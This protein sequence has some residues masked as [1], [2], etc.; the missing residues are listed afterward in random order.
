MTDPLRPPYESGA[1]EAR[2]SVGTWSVVT[3]MTAA[4]V[5]A[6]S[7]AVIMLGPPSAG[8]HLTEAPVALGQWLIEWSGSMRP[9]SAE[10]EE[11]GLALRLVAGGAAALVSVLCLLIVSGLW[12]QRLLLRKA[13]YFVHWAVGARRIQLAARLLGEGRVWVGGAVVLTLLASAIIVALIERT[14]PGAAAVSPNMAATAIVLLGLGVVLARWEVGVG[15]V[16]HEA[17]RSR[18]WELLASPPIVGAVGFAA[19]SGV[20]VLARHAP[21]PSESSVRSAGVVI[22][23]SLG[24]LPVES[25]GEEIISWTERARA[26]GARIGFASAGA[27]RETGP[28]DVATVECG[29]CFEGG[30]PMPLKVARVEVH[31]V[32]PDT[33][34]HLGI[35]VSS[36]RDFDDGLDRGAPGAAIVS[37]ALA[38]R[39][40]ERGQPLGKRL[41]IGDS[42]WMTVVGVVGDRD[43]AGIPAEYA[44]YVPL[45]QVRPTEIELITDGSPVDVESVLATAPLGAALGAP[46]TR[47]E[48]FSVHRWFRALLNVLGI[49][50]AAL[51]GA[52]L[53]VSAG[54][55][56][57]AARYEVAV[58]RAV[59]ARQKG[60]W[61]FYLSFAGRRLFIALAFGAWLSLF[62]GAGLTE[63]YASI[64]QIDWTVWGAVA[65][66]ISVMYVLGSAPPFVRAANSPMLPTLDRAD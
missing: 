32:A 58:R 39:H 10:E 24:A 53:W 27:S 38:N 50:A 28:T 17:H 64:P 60:V 44:I 66:W 52:G 35:A 22:G 20:G 54:S 26:G 49:A 3:I 43:D 42:E 34:V 36:G 13:E 37:Q 51:L 62:L 14:F 16:S 15:R 11:Q 65:A 46:R 47:A 45:A 2:R 48:I 1:A 19:L 57:D 31:A 9:P 6:F 61:R 5:A 7:L 40:F 23:A 18:L 33:F 59:G 56:A 55:E 12:R 25:R 8:H 4:C 21:Y 29:R 30:I 41:R 63:A